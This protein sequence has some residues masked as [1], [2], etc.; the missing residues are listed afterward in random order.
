MSC[1]KAFKEFEN[2]FN[3]YWMLY[4]QGHRDL[5]NYRGLAITPDNI[6]EINKIVSELQDNYEEL[7]DAFAFVRVRQPIVEAALREHELFMAHLKQEGAPAP[8]DKALE[9][10]EEGHA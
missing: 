5:D 7:A 6:D 10:I 9:P 2:Q 1:K 3:K 8:E 4:V